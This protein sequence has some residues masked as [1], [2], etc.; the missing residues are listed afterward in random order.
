[1]SVSRACYH[2]VCTGKGSVLAIYRIEVLLILAAVAV[3]FLY[4]ELGAGWFQKAEHTLG[5][6]ARRRGL[7]VA[8]VGLLALAARAAVLPILP[9]P[10]VFVNDEFSHLLVADTLLHGRLTNPTHPMWVHFETFHVIW[11]PTYASMYPPAIGMTLAAGRLI[12]GHPFVGVWLSIGAMCAAIC[13]MLQGWLPPGWALLGGALAVI[14]FGF[15]NYWSN[16]YFGG[17][18]P[19]IGGALLFGALPRLKREQRAGDALLMGL[20]V[21]VLANSRPYEGLIATIPVA[22]SLFLWLLKTSRQ[23]LKNVLQHVLVPLG[24]VLVTA[25]VATMYYFWRVTGSPFRMPVEVNRATYAVA[26]FFPWQPPRPEPPYRHELLKFFYTKFEMVDYNQSRTFAGWAIFASVKSVMLWM[27]YVGPALSIPLVTLPW[28]IRDRRTRFLFLALAVFTAGVLIE[29]YLQMHYAAPATCLVFA[30]ILQCMRHLRAWRWRGKPSGAFLVR[31]VALIC[32]AMLGVIA[33]RVARRER[34]PNIWSNKSLLDVASRSQT[35][36]EL[37]SRA[38]KQLVIVRYGPSHVIHDEWVY[39]DAGIDGAKVVWARDMGSA[40]NREL[41]E[42]FKN[43]HVWLA[44]PDNTP[45][46][47]TAYPSKL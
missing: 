26:Q 2:L 22:A 15:F 45:P 16:S 34:L 44:E 40:K 39:N 8:A 46:K 14:Q 29:V 27:F 23:A 20:G 12:G 33:P 19:A 38:G 37:D 6:L 47:L 18:V 7:A 41:I 13:W 25:A 3:A 35:L 31:S 24:L 43:R 21:A 36:A 30:A 11:K 28:A 4:P 10:P 9:V 1:M 32:L 17:A 5:R 42:Y